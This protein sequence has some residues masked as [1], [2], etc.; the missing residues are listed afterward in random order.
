MGFKKATSYF[1]ILVLAFTVVLFSKD[2]RSEENKWKLAGKTKDNNF[3]VYYDTASVKYLRKD[4]VSL[5]LKRERSAEGIEQFK[6][7]FYASVKEAEEKSGEK[8]NG[9]IEPVLKALLERET[10][11]YPVEIDCAKNEIRVPPSRM[12]QMN[13]VIVD[14]IEPGTTAEKIRN[15]VCPK[16]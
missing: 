10:K 15:D 8:V 9:P 3:L 14:D 13:F 12:Q 6:K 2:A 4:Y 1:L 7:D 16:H 5:T 11:E